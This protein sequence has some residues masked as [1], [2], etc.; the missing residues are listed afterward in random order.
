MICSV[1]A[2]AFAGANSVFHQA[3]WV[4]LPAADSP[5][6]SPSPSESGSLPSTE[7]ISKTVDKATQGTVDILNLL[8]WAA[9]G[10]G[11]GIALMFLLHL[12]IGVVAHR[13]RF[14]RLVKNRIIV[15]AYFTC[16]VFGAHLGLSYAF[17]PSDSAASWVP[18]AKHAVLL[19]G[20]AG[21][22]WLAFAAAGVIEDVTARQ[23]ERHDRKA[24]RIE[25]QAQVLRRVLQAVI[26]VL[27][28]IGM[29]LTYPAARAAM[30]SVLASAGIASL[31]AGLAAQS[32]LANMFAGLQVAFADAIRVGDVVM[33]KGLD[34]AELQGTIEEITLTYV[35]VLLWD[36]RRMIV[37]S[38]SFTQQPFQN[39]TRQTPQLLGAV[40][41]S[42][43]WSAPVSQIRAEADRL[44]SSSD[45]WDGRSAS[46]QV[47]ASNERYMTVRIVVSAENSG[48]LWDLRCYLRERLYAWLV[49]NAPYALPRHRW[50][51]QVVQQINQD[52]SEERVAHLAQELA[53]ISRTDADTASDMQ[54]D[55]L[56]TA[57]AIKQ[58]L[59]RGEGRAKQP[60]QKN[61]KNQKGQKGQKKNQRNDKAASSIHEARLQAAKKKARRQIKRR[62]LRSRGIAMPRTGQETSILPTQPLAPK[63][64]AAVAVA[65]AKQASEHPGSKRR[66]KKRNAPSAETTP[67]V[68]QTQVLATVL[69][70][71]ERDA[72]TVA[73]EMETTMSDRMFSGSPEAEE[74]G[75][76]LFSGP[77]NEEVEGTAQQEDSPAQQ[78]GE[79]GTV[80]AEAAPPANKTIDVTDA[81]TSETKLMPKIQEDE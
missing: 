39:L 59:A 22:G 6:P 58:V 76:Q 71:Q 47:S 38:T 24:R 14:V 29:A 34:G 67:D 7:D 27:T 74:R 35:V 21:I 31:I 32:T 3:Q 18:A 62:S 4:L 23:K 37:P 54:I 61:Q 73:P 75:Q 49:S 33:I 77:H 26:I 8:M 41:L 48:K 40:E 81:G 70:Q 78:K 30:A 17:D 64:A 15:P 42:L 5:S 9:I 20:Y 53:Q 80:K 12:I 50:V 28:I 19:L 25:T 1:V 60:G 2:R 69:E 79:A 51:Q 45:L 56:D 55:K 16:A 68:A 36:D 63:D 43:D 72:Q 13:Q 44:L 11:I 46:V 52:V 66:G 10:A 65:V 57:E